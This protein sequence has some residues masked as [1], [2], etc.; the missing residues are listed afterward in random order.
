MGTE[1]LVKSSTSA[2]V[3]SES[4]GASVSR[5]IKKTHLVT[6][7]NMLLRKCTDRIFL[8]DHCS[9]RFYSPSFSSQIWEFWEPKTGHLTIIVM[10]HQI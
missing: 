6:E 9:V 4:F 7:T 5:N 8:M 10:F 1:W 3:A 2:S